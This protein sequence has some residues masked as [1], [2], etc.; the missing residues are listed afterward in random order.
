MSDMFSPFVELNTSGGTVRNLFSKL[1]IWLSRKEPADIAEFTFKLGLPDLGLAKDSAIDISIG[2]D[3]NNSWKVFSGYVSEPMSPRFLCK[4]EA[5]KLFKTNITKTFLD[6]V[7][8]DV[9]K[10]G[11]QQAGVSTFSLVEDVYPKKPSFVAAGE[12]VSDLVKRVNTT[13][14]LNFDHYFDGEK[15]FYWDAPKPRPGPVYSYQYGE[16]IIELEFSADRE[17][18]GQRSAGDTAGGGRLLTVS[19]PFVGHSQEIEIIWPEVASSRYITET[20]HH[21]INEQGS[22]RTEIFFRELAEVA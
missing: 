1:D 13:W 7:P 4:D 11:L 18:S 21:F 9:I 17:P 2:Y 6:V 16:N 19:S 5:I 22:L 10:F 20:V 8:Q 3:G 15:K 12:N 14:G